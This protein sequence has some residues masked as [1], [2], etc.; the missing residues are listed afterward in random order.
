MKKENTKLIVWAVIALVVGVLT[1]EQLQDKQYLGVDELP[2]TNEQ[3]AEFLSKTSGYT[4]DKEL[5]LKCMNDEC[6]EQD[7][8]GLPGYS[9]QC[10]CRNPVLWSEC[11]C[12]E[13][14]GSYIGQTYIGRPCLERVVWGGIIVVGTLK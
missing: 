6:N 3:K 7:I 14:C 5:L 10:L 11:W 8:R 12:G 1:S 4:A 9:I 2:G 13:E